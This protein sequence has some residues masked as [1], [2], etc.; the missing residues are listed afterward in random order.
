MKIQTATLG[1]PKSMGHLQMFL[2]AHG[3]DLPHNIKKN[4][5][6]GKKPKASSD[7]NNDKYNEISGSK[8]EKALKGL[9]C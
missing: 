3:N 4:A 6:M 8:K 9:Q 7:P 1:K 2:E 5:L